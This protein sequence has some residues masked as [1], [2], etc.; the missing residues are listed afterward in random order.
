[1]ETSALLAVGTYRCVSVSAGFVISDIVV[2]ARLASGILQPRKAE[3]QK[4]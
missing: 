1:M 3:R 4:K 2:R